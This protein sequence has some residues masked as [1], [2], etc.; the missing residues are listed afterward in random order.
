MDNSRIRTFPAGERRRF[1]V[2]PIG[3]DPNGSCS[4]EGVQP[5]SIRA[6]PKDN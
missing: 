5:D 1:E 3:V 6:R 4:G 2:A